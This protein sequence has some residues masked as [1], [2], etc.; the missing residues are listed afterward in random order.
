MLPLGLVLRQR[1][2]CKAQCRDDGDKSIH[3]SARAEGALN[4]G[5]SN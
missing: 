4:A 2:G 3:V 1:A 5:R